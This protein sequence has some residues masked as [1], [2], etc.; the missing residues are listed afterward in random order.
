M[1][2]ERVKI[3]ISKC[4]YPILKEILKDLKWDI[5]FEDD[6]DIIWQDSALSP[7]SLSLLNSYQRIN[8]FPGIYAIS[9]KD[10]LARH[11][12]TMELLNPGEFQFF[13]ETWVVPQEFQSLK[14]FIVSTNATLIVKPPNLS[15]GKGIFLTRWAQDIPETCVVQR[16]L[17]NPFLLDG[18]KF[19]L[20]IYV[21]ITGFD[22]LRVYIHEDGLVRLATSPYCKPS[23][24]NMSNVFMHL[25]NYAINKAS[26]GYLVGRKGE[27][28]T[29]HKRSFKVFLEKLE[30]DGLNSRKLIRR[31]DD[32]ILKT[33]C[34]V[35]PFLAHQYRACQP[36]DSYSAICFQIL[37]FD[38]F[39]D[40]RLRP[41]L[42]EVNHTPSFSTDSNLDFQIKKAVIKDCLKMVGVRA[43]CSKIFE[44]EKNNFLNEKVYKS[45][46]KVRD[47]RTERKDRFLQQQIENENCNMGGY[48]R[49]FP[50]ENKERYQ[51]FMNDAQGIFSNKTIVKKNKIEMKETPK[52]RKS[53]VHRFIRSKEP[54]QVQRR[55]SCITKVSLRPTIIQ[56][57][58]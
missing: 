48:R 35:Q 1:S 26:P 37:G 21:L 15:Q 44:Q 42:L 45:F 7:T 55:K 16:Y 30:E 52:I 3:D 20:R 32:I 4:Q 38:I 50:C 36:N 54:V 17:E 9:R 13:P 40:S 49:V 10:Y 23:D 57:T 43:E 39:L 33:L 8:H 12:K 27:D 2:Q 24:M 34:T 28:F 47:L 31:I 53:T 41:H 22:P 58:L 29:G 51:K 19:D 56:L 11:L 14:T 25:T 6:P 18:F 5:D 46:G